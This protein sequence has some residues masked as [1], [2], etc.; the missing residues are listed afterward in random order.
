MIRRNFL[1]DADAAQKFIDGMAQRAIGF[2]DAQDLSEEQRKE[3]FRKLLRDSFDMQ[4]I[5]RFSLGTS[6]KTATAE[7]KSEYQKLFEKMI[8]DAVDNAR[9][10]ANGQKMLVGKS[11]TYVVIPPNEN[12][13]FEKTL[14]LADMQMMVDPVQEWKQIFMDVWRFERDYF[15]DAGMHGVDW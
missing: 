4:T 8:V 3:E 5:G 12:Q 11:G 7:E 14:P 6:W 13:K 2:L 1:T 10:S 9:L 15:Y